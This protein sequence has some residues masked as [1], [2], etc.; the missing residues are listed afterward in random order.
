M[1][2]T[3]RVQSRFQQISEVLAKEPTL[4]PTQIANMT[5]IPR[6]SVNRYLQKIRQLTPTAT[7]TT[8]A[9]PTSCGSPAADI[10]KRADDTKYAILS[11]K[12]RDALDIIEEQQSMLTTLVDIGKAP[13]YRPIVARRS[14]KREVV[15][16]I[17]ASD[18]HIEEQVKSAVT[19]GM[20]EYNLE[21]AER[22]VA[23]F[24][25]NACT[26]VNQT[27]RDS[28]VHTIVLAILGDIINGVL[29]DE[30]LPHLSPTR[31]PLSPSSVSALLRS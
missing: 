2:R 17:V 3:D 19:N 28:K 24:F 8:A 16:V 23:Q 12:Y 20:N 25:A 5:G 10:R 26:L 15:P 31:V 14:S 27:K 21:I 18:W 1:T 6:T 9:D 13:E 4:T 29:R 30:D 11:Q 7:A 22:S